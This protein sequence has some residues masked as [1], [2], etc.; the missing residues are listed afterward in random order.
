MEVNAELLGSGPLASRSSHV[1][2]GEPRG[3]ARTTSPSSVVH[4]NIEPLKCGTH[5][6]EME[7]QWH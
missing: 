7:T 5:L 1:G 4:Q 6:I 3:L 2:R